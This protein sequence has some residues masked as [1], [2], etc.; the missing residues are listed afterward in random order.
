MLCVVAAGVTW[1]NRTF[2]AEWGLRADHTSVVDAAGAI[3]VIGGEGD[4][5]YRDVWA[6]TDGGARAGLGQRGSRGTPRVLGVLAG[7]MGVPGGLWSTR[8]VL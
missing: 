1:T 8:G 7:Y 3:Y 2:M 6:S 4:D 5:F